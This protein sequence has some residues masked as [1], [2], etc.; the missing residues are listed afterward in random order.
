MADAG[1]GQLQS[2][3][4][5]SMVTLTPGLADK[6]FGESSPQTV[7]DNFWEFLNSELMTANLREHEVDEFMDRADIAFTNML[8]GIPEDKW[9]D[10]RIV[11]QEWV[12]TPDGPRLQTKRIFSVVELWDQM[13][14]KVKIKCCNSRNGHLI[15]TVT[16]SRSEIS[17]LYEERGTARAPGYSLPGQAPQE[18]KSSGWR[19]I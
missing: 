4:V 16:S 11:E 12:Q 13:L 10:F 14:T 6:I 2:G 18:Q 17:Q 8:T 7:I 3:A 1:T 5:Y 19:P 9:N 15:K